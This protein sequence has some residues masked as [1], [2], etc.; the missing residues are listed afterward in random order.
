MLEVR[1]WKSLWKACG[2]AC[3]KRGKAINQPPFMGFLEKP[4]DIN[5]LWII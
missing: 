4:P 3:G 5:R 1:L 2:K